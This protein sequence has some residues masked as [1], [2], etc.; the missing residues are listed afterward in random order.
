MKPPTKGSAE[1]LPLDARCES[2]LYSFAGLPTKGN[3]PECG[4]TY[5]FEYLY[6]RGSL[7][8]ETCAKCRY[9]LKGLALRGNCPECGETYRFDAPKRERPA[10]GWGG[11]WRWFSDRLPRFDFKIAL[12]LLILATA[13]FLGITGWIAFRKIYKKVVLGPQGVFITWPS[14]SYR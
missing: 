5:G 3:C 13:I 12:V 4:I 9:P 2:C 6:R 8:K 1:N 10:A 14:A 11:V 7:A